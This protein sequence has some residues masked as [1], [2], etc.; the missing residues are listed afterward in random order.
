MKD[1]YFYVIAIALAVGLIALALVWPQG[2]SA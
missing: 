1:R 2:A